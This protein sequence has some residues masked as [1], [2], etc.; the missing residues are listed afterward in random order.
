MGADDWPLWRD[1]R[2]AA[3]TR[4][5][6]AFRARAADWAY[7]GEWQWRE[8]LLLPGAY[9]LVA[10]QDGAAVGLVRG[11]PAD[12]GVIDVHS[13]WVDPDLRGQGVGGRL[14]GAVEAWA[15]EHGART[16]RLDVF[17][18]NDAAIGL[19]RRLGFA[20][21]GEAHD[22]EIVMTKDLAA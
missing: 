14:I 8:R 9:N 1:V 2:L 7:G 6:E 11:V 17:A 12:D 21:T 10:E 3:L 5:P 19:Y 22:R 13:V 4:S 16:L 15:R 18:D 20:A